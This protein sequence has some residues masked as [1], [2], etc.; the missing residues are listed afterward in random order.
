[1]PGPA[2]DPAPSLLRQAEAL[3]DSLICSPAK[4]NSRSRDPAIPELGMATSYHVSGNR[5]FVLAIRDT[6]MMDC[7]VN[8]QR[9]QLG[10]NNF[11]GGIRTQG[12]G[13]V[14]NIGIPIVD[15]KTH[16]PDSPNV[17]VN[18]SGAGRERKTRA[19]RHLAEVE[20]VGQRVVA[21]PSSV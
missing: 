5:S 4:L 9:S 12:P 13:I 19:R 16:S 11:P 3:R 17:T 2:T 15:L 10:D 7:C 6:R 8:P 1:M 20:T 14:P 21:L 18:N